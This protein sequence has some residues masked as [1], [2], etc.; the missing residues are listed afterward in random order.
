MFYM[1]VLKA[2][3]SS[4]YYVGYSASLTNRVAEHK[5]AKTKIW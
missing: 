2:T 3:N 4:N 1:Y 5:S